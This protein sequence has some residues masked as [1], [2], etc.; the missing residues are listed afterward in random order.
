MYPRNWLR[1]LVEAAVRG[2]E[3]PSVVST[4]RIAGQSG[5]ASAVPRWAF[6][7]LRPVAGFFHCLVIAHHDEGHVPGQVP[8]PVAVPGSS[9]LQK[10]SGRLQRV[11]WQSLAV[12]SQTGPAGDIEITL[13]QFSA[14]V[15][16]S[17]P[18]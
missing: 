2:A 16:A 12:S 17:D 6:G 5:L 8:V 13:L 18:T 10:H 1:G 7:P 11:F 15:T 9:D 3:R 4:K 14:Q